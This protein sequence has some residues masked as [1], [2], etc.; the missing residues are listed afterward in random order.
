MRSFVKVELLFLKLRVFRAFDLPKLVLVYQIVVYSVGKNFSFA[1]LLRFD[2][3]I[4][5]ISKYLI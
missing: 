1:A 2:L 5:G 3:L 4:V